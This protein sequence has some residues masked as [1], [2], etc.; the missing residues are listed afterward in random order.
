MIGGGEGWM[1]DEFGMLDD[2]S[3]LPC[4]SFNGYTSNPQLCKSCHRPVIEHVEYMTAHKEKQAK[5]D[6]EKK[7]KEAAAEYAEKR[8]KLIELA[9]TEI[10]PEPEEEMV[11]IGGIK[12]PKAYFDKLREVI[13]E[14]QRESFT[15]MV[16]SSSTVPFASTSYVSGVKDRWFGGGI[17]KC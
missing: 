9:G 13:L 12:M 14:Q 11:E 15:S 1:L 16:A 4:K 8:E 17:K 7:E 2:L 6:K 10:T 5:K 3:P